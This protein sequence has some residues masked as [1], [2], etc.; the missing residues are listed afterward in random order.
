MG[1]FGAV[2]TDAASVEGTLLLEQGEPCSEGW[3][4]VEGKNQNLTV[5]ETGTFRM[6][7]LSP[8]TYVLEGYCA[9]LKGRTEVILE[10]GTEITSVKLVADLAIIDEQ[11]DVNFSYS[12]MREDPV[13]RVGLNREQIFLVPHFG[14][15]MYRAVRLLPGVTGSDISARFQVRG[16]DYQDTQVVLDGAELYN[17][18]HLQDFQGVFS[19]ID[20]EIIG[21]VDLLPGTFPVEYGRR[22]AAVLE[23]TSLRPKRKRTTLGLSFSNA[24]LGSSGQFGEDRGRWV[25]NARRGYLDIVLRLAGGGG[26]NEPS[27]Q[28]WDFFSKVDWDLSSSQTLGVKVLAADDTID[29]EDTDDFEDIDVDTNYGSSYLWLSHLST[30]GHSAV[31]ETVASWSRLDRERFFDFVDENE[32][33]RIDDNRETEVLG[34]KQDWS[35][36]KSQHLF[37]FGVDARQIESDYDYRNEIV[38]PYPINSPFFPP[39][40]SQLTFEERVDSDTYGVYLADRMTFGAWTVE[41]GVRWDRYDLL[42]EDEISPRVNVA[43]DLKDRGVVRLGWGEFRQTQLPFELNIEY[44]EADFLVSSLSEQWSVGWENR[45]SRGLL[46]RTEF[47]SREENQPGRRFETLFE[48]FTAFPEATV[49]RISVE[50]ERRRAEGAEVYLGVPGNEKWQGWMS[51]AW[52]SVEDRIFGEWI[53]VP[54]DQTHAVTASVTWKPGTRWNFTGVW[55]YHTGWPTTPLTTTATFSETGE[56]TLNYDIGQPYSDRLADYHRM[57]LRASYRKDLKRSELTFFIDVQNLYNRE[58]A[59]G[60]EIDEPT[61]GPATD[62]VAAV[63]FSEESWLGI[64]PSF[65]VK[66][67]F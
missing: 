32:T 19:I 26:D 47:Y 29:Y 57:D 65:G 24:W 14:D 28:Y 52:S 44:G 61:I 21:G 16:S 9:G 46:L 3:V 2:P 31:V 34:F 60:L 62:G 39:G 41:L 4:T 59:R 11:M 49:D 30:L 51:Y 8:G 1:G 36:S 55:I 27:P 7:G 38:N 43:L 58:N 66:W 5:G 50:T 64:L 15:D 18:F 56:A 17:P 12:L 6:T 35:F 45:F 63:T 54:H 33:F 25:V 40:S 42:D 23:M 10:E 13:G 22:S 37:K 20:G 67:E 53:P 48:P